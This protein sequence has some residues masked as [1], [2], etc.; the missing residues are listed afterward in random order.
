MNKNLFC[1]SL[2]GVLAGVAVYAQEE[3]TGY[4]LTDLGPLGPAGQVLNIS[5]NSVISGAV[6]VADGSDHAVL[7]HKRLMFDIGVHG[8]GGA[9]SIAFGVNAS[10]QAVGGAETD[11]PDPHAA[12]FCGFKAYGVSTSGAACVAFIWQ[13]GIMTPLATLGGYNGTASQI[14]TVGEVA[15]ETESATPDPDCPHKLQLKPVTWQNGKVRELPTYPGDPDGVAYAINDNGQVVGSTG[16]CKDF[17]PALQLSIQPLHPRLW[18][19]DGTVKDLGSLGGTGHGFANLAI[20]LNNLGH[21]VGLSDLAGDT[22]NHAFLW[23]HE[24]GMQDLGTLPGDIGS[25]AI[26]I[27]DADEIVGLSLDADFNPRA[28][29]WQAGV[30]TDLNT[31]VSGTTLHLLFASALNSHG[32]IAGLAVDTHTGD[33]HGYLA[34]P[35][36]RAVAHEAASEPAVTSRSFKPEDARR[37]LQTVQRFVRF[38]VRIPEPR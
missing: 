18:E 37:L 20:N 28:F 1:A 29:V 4:T 25:G 10:S 24:K 6:T 5:R 2:I 11:K 8:L 16:T 35:H 12:D 7:W 17:N 15:G 19:P 23:T 3:P 32:E 33:L 26:A 30:M 13:N 22:V 27:N 34:T 31:L 14:N 9:N 38:G 36:E 21:V